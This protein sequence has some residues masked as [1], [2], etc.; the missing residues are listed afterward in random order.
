M[1]AVTGFDDDGLARG[2]WSMDLVHEAG[3]RLSPMN[4][5]VSTADPSGRGAKWGLC[6]LDDAESSA[7][8]PGAVESGGGA[9]ARFTSGTAAR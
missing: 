5:M 3:I 2:P 6:S 9:K 1:P 4:R 7:V 8:E